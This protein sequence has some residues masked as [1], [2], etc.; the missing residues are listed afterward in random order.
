MGCCKP[1][2]TQDVNGLGDVELTQHR[3]VLLKVWLGSDTRVLD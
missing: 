1:S 2:L 3:S